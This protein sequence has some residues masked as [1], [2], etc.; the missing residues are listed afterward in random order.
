MGR[1]LAVV[2]SLVGALILG[3]AFYRSFG[4][5]AP[6]PTGEE[7]APSDFAFT[8]A[9]G[10]E[11]KNVLDTFAGRFTKDLIADGTATTPLKLPSQ[12]M[13]RIYALANEMQIMD[14]PPDL[15][16]KAGETMVFVTPAFAYRLLIRMHGATREVVYDASHPSNDPKAA[17]LVGL[18]NTIRSEVM[19]TKEYKHLPPAKGGYD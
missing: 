11:G 14:Y 1:R 6:A 5:A 18:I 13:A 19:A 8:A 7:A 15:A 10:I 12:S 2:L 3:L 17:K 16:P 4:A 9:W